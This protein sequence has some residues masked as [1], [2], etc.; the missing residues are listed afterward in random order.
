MAQAVEQKNDENKK[1]ILVSGANK[2]I[3]LELCKL[4]IKNENVQIILG[5]RNFNYIPIPK[6]QNKAKQ[7]DN[8]EAIGKNEAKQTRIQ[9]LRDVK[10]KDVKNIDFV[11]LDIV[12]KKSVNRAVQTVKEKYK[13]IDILVNNAGMAFKGN[14]FDLNGVYFECLS[15]AKNIQTKTKTIHSCK[16]HNKL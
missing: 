7:P 12:D 6:E 13:Q 4:L 14:V 5:C 8:Y 1:V 11:E 16:H 9:I 10:F 2:G 3:G 15:F